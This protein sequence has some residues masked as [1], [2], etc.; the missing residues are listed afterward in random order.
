M[1]IKHEYRKEVM[2]RKLS[3][4]RLPY[5]PAAL[6]ILIFTGCVSVNDASVAQVRAPSA[7][8]RLATGAEQRPLEADALRTLFSGAYV[9]PVQAADII[10]D[11]PPGEIFR[12]DGVYQRIVGRTRLYGTFDVRGNLVCV[13]G[14]GFRQQCRQVIPLGNDRY[15][16]VDVSNGS[17]VIVSIASH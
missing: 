17:T 4:A 2:R 10:I 5:F 7:E 16:L 3:M 8:M 1:N 15:S 11:H 6:G 13:Q 14:D 12:S 9:T